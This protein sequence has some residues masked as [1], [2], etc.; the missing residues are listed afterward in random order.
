M[1][2]TEKIDD[3]FEIAETDEDGEIV[4]H[5]GDCIGWFS[6]VSPDCHPSSC[7]RSE[8]C[9]SY[10]LNRA[11]QSENSA[12]KSLDEI[13]QDSDKNIV[14]KKASNSAMADLGRQAFFDKI[15]NFV[16]SKTDHDNIKYNPKRTTA[17]IKVGGKVVVFL[18]RKRSEVHVQ[19]GGR[20]KDGA[21]IRILIGESD[22]TYESQI[23]TFLNENNR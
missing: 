8:Y 15:V 16:A 1:S 3:E 2:D 17:S 4:L 23:T 13:G 14:Q 19:I 21:T 22:G 12:K 18:S 7:L 5:P 11:N 20:N 6:S 9:K 10:T